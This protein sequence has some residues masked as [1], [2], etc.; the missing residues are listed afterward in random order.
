M[1]RILLLAL[2]LA[3]S[4]G[5]VAWRSWDA[6]LDEAER[7]GKPIMVDAVRDACRYC[8]RMESEVFSDPEVAAQMEGRLIPVKVNISRE[9]MP[10]GLKVP[11]TPSFYFFTADRKLVKTVPG[12]WNRE[13]F[14]LILE[15]VL[16]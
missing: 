8:E 3:L 14:I 4:A 1:N 6:A 12:A 10:R 7:T 16:P 5:E 2:P 15:E 11:M 13:D 9:T